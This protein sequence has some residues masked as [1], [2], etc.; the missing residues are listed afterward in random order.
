MGELAPRL[1]TVVGLFL[2]SAA[3]AQ[4]DLVQLDPSRVMRGAQ[5]ARVAGGTELARELR[6]WRV[7]AYAVADLRRA[8][9]VQHSRPE[10]LLASNA[11]A[12]QATDP[13]VSMQWW[14]PVIGADRQEAPGPGKPVTVVDSGIDLSHPEF[15]GRPNT[16]ALNEQTVDEEDE[17]HGTEVSSVVAAPNNGVGIVGV[18]PDAILRVWDASPFGFLNEGAAIQGI[19]EAARRGP[20][21]INLSFGGGDDDPLLEDAISFAFRSGSLVVAAAGNEGFEGSPDNFPGFYPH[22]LTGGATNDQGRVAGFSTISATVDLVAPGVRIPV[23]EPTSEDPSGY[24]LVSG[25]S[26]ASPLV[27]GAAAW[28]W[29]RRP[30]LDN[31]QLFELMRRS[32]V[33]IGAPGHDRASG[34]GLLNIPNALAARTPP[35]D[36]HEPNEQPNEIEPN[37]LFATGTPPLTRPAQATGQISAEVDRT[38][39]PIDLYRVWAP[40]GQTLRVRSTGAVAVRLLRRSPRRSAPLAVGKRG[41]AAYR[42]ATKRGVYVYVEVRPAAVRVADYMLRLTAARR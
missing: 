31:T 15:S 34:Y 24:I 23:A 7:P 16:T 33:D 26:F 17:D 11:A 13:M 32:A 18:Y 42:N 1:L 21:V 40:A 38:E 36:P 19:V 8:G 41:L 9:V 27:A 20:G 5:L 10:R 35:R 22:V 37:G 30:D 6:L 28:I 39:D 12:L 25:T 4:A 29:T 3:P 14:I 2:A